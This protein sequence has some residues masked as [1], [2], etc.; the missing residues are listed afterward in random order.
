MLYL[1]ILPAFRSS[2]RF[3]RLTLFQSSSDQEKALV[4]LS[5]VLL[6]SIVIVIGPTPPGTGV[7]WLALLLASLKSTSPTN[8]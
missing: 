7:M 4:A 8:R 1:Q 6:K 2:L 5:T 3:L